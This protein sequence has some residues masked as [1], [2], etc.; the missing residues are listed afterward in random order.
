MGHPTGAPNMHHNLAVLSE[1]AKKFT[2]RRLDY[3]G[4]IVSVCAT[5]FNSCRRTIVW[6]SGGIL[7]EKI[8][9]F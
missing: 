5:Y 3:I 1:S 6:G 9:Y 2:E 4:W 8:V 7:Y